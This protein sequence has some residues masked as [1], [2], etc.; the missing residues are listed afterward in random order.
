MGRFED[1]LAGFHTV[2][3]AAPSFAPTWIN[4]GDVLR[5]LGRSGEAV[6]SF[7][8]ALAINP[9][10]TEVWVHRGDTLLELNRAD[11][12]LAS[13]D[14]ALKLAPSSAEAW[15]NRGTALQRLRR[16]GDA[17]ASYERALALKPDFAEA[18]YNRGSIEWVERRQYDAA[19]R[20]LERAAMLDPD[21]MSARRDLLLHLR[22][23][24]GDWRDFEHDVAALDAG[25]RAGK[26]VVAPFVYAALSVR[27]EDLQACAI[28]QASHHYPAA[29]AV[30]RGRR[31][32][33]DRIRLGYMSGEFRAQ[34][35]AFL[36]A[37]L[38]ELHDKTRFELIAFDNGAADSSLVRERLE[39]A[40]DRFVN[41]SNLSDKAAADQIA[42]EEVDILINLNGY[43]GEHRMGVFA[44]KPA[45]IQVNYL[46]FP[47]TLGASY[48]DYILADRFVIPENE[49]QFYVEK[50]IYL[51]DTYQANDSK[52]PIALSPLTRLEN[53][54]PENGFV[55]CNFNQSY[56]LVPRMFAVW[57]RI[58]A[59]VEGS[60]LW[61]LESNTLLP[62]NLRREA[63]QHG[64]AGDRL[65]FAPM[66]ELDRHLAR[67]KLA[68]L[69]LDSLPYNAHTTASDALWAGLPLLTCRG[70]AFPGRVAA[71]LL[72]AIGLP[73]LVTENF[74]D[75]EAL[76]LRLA[77]DPA[78]LDFMRRKLMA[79]RLTTP[80][81]D[82][83]RFR[84]N[85]ESA[86]TTMWEIF[87]R[88][89]NPKSFAVEPGY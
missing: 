18:L 34:A 44:R 76:A 56:K 65:I 19:V 24:R 9:G 61:M 25:V 87:Q 36:M 1:A 70:T 47:G 85:I 80:L 38:Y 26:G 78:L 75:Y 89:E 68:D 46:G 28:L 66:V 69:F 21:R 17:L 49:Q 30:W 64:I 20:D 32:C 7:D 58:L 5:R 86:Y 40:F 35:T 8:R 82:T 55:F 33:H 42:T 39:T 60:V 6:A 88:G 22:M 13:Y 53:G 31:C 45:P 67:L 29:P 51:P 84:R 15:N 54:L 73:E 43:F 16:S 41:I 4:G 52:R 79:N 10:L 23:H 74:V 72:H 2:A 27:P 12:A 59:Q 48:M 11:E 71:S 81:F 62:D 57:M 14:R 3:R 77:R 37:E 63:A 50:V 83:Q